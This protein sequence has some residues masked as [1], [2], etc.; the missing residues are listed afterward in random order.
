MPK[1]I[2]DSINLLQPLEAPEDAF[3]KIYDWILSVGRYL[4]VI[5]EIGVLAVFFSRFFS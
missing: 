2:S 4:L 1:K 3:A 5:V